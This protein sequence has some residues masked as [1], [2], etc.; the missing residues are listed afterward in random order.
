MTKRKEKKKIFFKIILIGALI[1]VGV[2]AVWAATLT[3]PN[4]ETFEERK[5]RQ[6]TKIYDRTGEFLLFDFNEDIRRTV[7]S[8]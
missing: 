4:L 3:I 1:T 2:I 6:S 7:V 5:I 8:N